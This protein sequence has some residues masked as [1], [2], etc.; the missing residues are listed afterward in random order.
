MSRDRIEG[1]RK[2]SKDHRKQKDAR[3]AAEDRDGDRPHM[4]AKSQ[5]TFGIRKDE[6]AR[7]IRELQSRYG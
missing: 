7:Q 1:T 2:H 4:G 3:P 6:A 5:R